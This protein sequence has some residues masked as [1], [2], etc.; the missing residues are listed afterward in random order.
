M[1]SFDPSRLAVDPSFGALPRRRRIWPIVLLV[2]GVLLAALVIVARFVNVSDYALVPG[3]AT[4]V[5]GLIKL[6]PAAAHPI[7]GH[8]LLTDVGVDNLNLLGYVVDKFFN[9]DDTIVSDSDLTA[10]LPVSEFNDEGTV[11]MEESELTAESVALRQLGY[12]V[13]EKDVGVTVYVIDPGSPAWRSLHVGDVITAVD[14]RA[15]TNPDELQSAVR[16]HD[17]GQ[18][19]T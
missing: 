8:V 12:Q 16:E 7:D 6:P 15:T 3:D 13:P 2:V 18:V 4:S 5:S 1:S 14:G 11:D 10:N 19:I 9:A 17:P